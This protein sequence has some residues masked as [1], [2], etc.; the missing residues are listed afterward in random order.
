MRIAY[1][2]NKD[3]SVSLFAI[4]ANIL[5]AA[6]VKMTF[7]KTGTMILCASSLLWA[8]EEQGRVL[9]TMSDILASLPDADRAK[10]L[11]VLAAIDAAKGKQVCLGAAGAL[12]CVDTMRDNETVYGAKDLKELSTSVDSG[13]DEAAMELAARTALKREASK[14]LMDDTTSEDLAERLVLWRKAG[15]KVVKLSDGKKPTYLDR[16][17]LFK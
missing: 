14:L 12:R 5:P 4:S 6:A 16:A 8:L 9:C 15:G 3:K 10:P 13:E 1:L 17:E 11:A 7:E 2:L